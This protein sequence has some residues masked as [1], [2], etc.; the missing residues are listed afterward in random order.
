MLLPATSLL[1]NK[2]P[3][4]SDVTVRSFVMVLTCCPESERPRLRCHVIGT[5]LPAAGSLLLWHN[6]PKAR[7]WS[8]Q[9]F[10][11]KNVTLNR[12]LAATQACNKL[13]R[14]EHTSRHD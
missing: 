9:L 6:Q 5:M 11:S 14:S 12:P 8:V 2:H 3:P 4:G 7:D 13:I 1:L 10:A